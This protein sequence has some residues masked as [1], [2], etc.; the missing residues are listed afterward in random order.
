MDELERRRPIE[1]EEI[2]LGFDGADEEDRT[3]VLAI[4]RDA[5][6]LEVYHVIR[7]ELEPYQLRLAA[8]GQ[9]VGRKGGRFSMSRRP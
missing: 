8:L 1:L 5:S 3:A 6:G 7:G 4:T 2:V 9:A